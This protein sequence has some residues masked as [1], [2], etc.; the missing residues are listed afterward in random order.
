MVEWK[1]GLERRFL[2]VE[3]S[4]SRIMINQQDDLKKLLELSRDINEDLVAA[5]EE[6]DQLRKFF[7]I[8]K[9]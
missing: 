1:F 5:R 2:E 3:Y 9:Q 4:L 7:G 6:N 8:M